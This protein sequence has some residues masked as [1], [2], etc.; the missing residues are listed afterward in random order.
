MVPVL[1]AE[2]VVDER[3]KGG[4]VQ[5]GV[6]VGG[7]EWRRAPHFF[8]FRRWEKSAFRENFD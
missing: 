5:G 8:A 7:R 6:A 4:G 1:L 2:C 3:K